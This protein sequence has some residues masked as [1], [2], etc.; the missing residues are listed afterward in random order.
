MIQ[1]VGNP[2]IEGMGIFPFLGIVEGSLIIC[3]LSLH[4]QEIGEIFKG[5]EKATVEMVEH[6]R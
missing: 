5:E 3:I 2:G 4:V 6:S 1:V